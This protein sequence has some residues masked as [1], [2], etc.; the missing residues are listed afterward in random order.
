MT[1]G[2][3][4]KMIKLLAFTKPFIPPQRVVVCPP[5][6]ASYIMQCVIRPTASAEVFSANNENLPTLQADRFSLPVNMG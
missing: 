4:C 2:L 5:I 6:A 3:Y 1:L